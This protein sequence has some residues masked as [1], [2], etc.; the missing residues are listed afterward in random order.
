MVIQLKKEQI[1]FKNIELIGI[2]KINYKIM[3]T[4]KWNC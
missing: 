1:N 3:F 4:N 2:F